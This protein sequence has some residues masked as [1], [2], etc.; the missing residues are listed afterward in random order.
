MR[1]GNLWRVALSENW[2]R[3]GFGLYVHWPFCQA[4]CPYCDFNSHV[5]AQ[6]DQQVWKRAYLAELDRVGALTRGR[7]LDSVFFG[8]GTP[9]LMA[10]ETVAA[11]LDR[12]AHW[13]QLGSDIEITLEANP[14]SAE[15]SR[16]SGYAAAGVNRLSMGIQALNDHDLKR[17]GRLHSA[18]E[19]RR[20][21][22][23]A[24]S[25]FTRV[26]F[27]LIYGRQDQSLSQWEKELD[28]ALRLS[29]DHLSLYQLTIE[30][31]TAF[32]DRFARGRLRG[33]PN[34]TLSADMYT[35][36]QDLC[37][38]HAMSAYEVSNHARKGSESRHNLIYW[39]SGDWAAIG[40]GAHA[41]LTLAG[42][43]KSAETWLQPGT[44]LTAVSTGT[45]ESSL[46]DLHPHDVAGEY[47]MM[48]MRL[49][50]GIDLDILYSYGDFAP[51][52]D[53]LDELKSLG[54]V[55]RD[56]NRLRTTPQGRLLLNSVIEKLLPDAVS[57][58]KTT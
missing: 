8:G 27:D 26:S 28:E 46:V 31:G 22:D 51:R 1:S 3:A 52:S 53:V 9:S 56:G 10:A 32:G 57:D 33:L 14:S 58:G 20:A 11:I 13:W 48:G 44:W 5:S 34:E 39:R 16:F 4:K 17:L 36:T 38:S 40:P 41:R 18:A 29:V 50:E 25:L 30:P 43:R 23:L 6:I 42:T 15:A 45:C 49:N 55:T 35:L 37:D 24:R 19:A 54:M 12:A 7:R 2:R 21:F 47:I